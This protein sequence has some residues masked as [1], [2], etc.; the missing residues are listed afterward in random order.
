MGKYNLHIW[1]I[2]EDENL[3]KFGVQ[4]FPVNFCLIFRFLI[5]QEIDLHKR[6]CKAGGPVGGGQITALYHLVRSMV[7]YMLMMVIMDLL[8]VTFSSWV[9]KSYSSL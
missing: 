7:S 4:I 3:V 9:V 8:T 5:R 2:L 6:I 1:K